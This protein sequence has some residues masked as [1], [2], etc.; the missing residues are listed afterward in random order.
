MITLKELEEQG[1]FCRAAGRSLETTALLLQ[2][3]GKDAK[4]I[5]IYKEDELDFKGIPNKDRYY[6]FVR[7]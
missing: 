1:L 5:R 4:E 2:N 3:F 7:R 6:S